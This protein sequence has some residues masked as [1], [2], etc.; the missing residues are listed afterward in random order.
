MHHEIREGMGLVL[1][2]ARC[3]NRAIVYLTKGCTSDPKESEQPQ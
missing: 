2:K 1:L 3:V